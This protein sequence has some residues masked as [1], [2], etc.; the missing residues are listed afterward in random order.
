MS[1][2]S[3]LGSQTQAFRF[4]GIFRA[5][6]IAEQAGDWRK[7]AQAEIPPLVD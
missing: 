7:G 5:D 4:S 2:G 6:H 3:C 1:Y